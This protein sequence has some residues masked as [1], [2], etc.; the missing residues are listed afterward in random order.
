MTNRGG[1]L[2][3]VDNAGSDWSGLRYLKEWT[4]ISKSFDIAT[5]YFDV[6]ALLE[7][8]QHWQ[9]VSK[10]RILMGDEQTQKT[11]K[12]LLEALRDNAKKAVDHNLEI[13]KNENPFLKG[14][15]AITEAI[16]NGQIE[17]KVYNKSKFHAKAYITHSKLDVVGSTALV[18][19]L[20]HI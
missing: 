19:S 1:D 14:A 2:F 4:E 10:I 13:E 16:R 8:D 18:L 6:G 9:K 3:I 15:P 20:I 7:L 11:K 12:Q 5:G 17:C